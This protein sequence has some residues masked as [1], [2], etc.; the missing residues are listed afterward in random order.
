MTVT[1]TALVTTAGSRGHR[2]PPA[3]GRRRRYTEDQVTLPRVIL[4]TVAQSI[5]HAQALAKKYTDGKAEASVD[6]FLARRREES[7]E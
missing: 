5:T 7:G 3:P 4:R 2:T 6:A 1:E